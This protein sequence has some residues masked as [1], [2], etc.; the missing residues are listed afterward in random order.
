MA[1]T[2]TWGKSPSPVVYRIPVT[3]LVVHRIKDLQNSARL[4]EVKE[5]RE[6]F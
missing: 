6:I 1:M 4:G 2:G 5:V 3:S